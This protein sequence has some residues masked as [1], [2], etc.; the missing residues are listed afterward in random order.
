MLNFKTNDFLI[1]KISFKLIIINWIT[2]DFKFNFKILDFQYD[3]YLKEQL[4]WGEYNMVDAF[5]EGKS[6]LI[7]GCTGFVGK[8][9]L[10]KILFSLPQVKKVYVLVRPKKATLAEER[11]RKEIID[12][13]IFDRLRAR[14]ANFDSFIQTK[15][16]PIEG[17]MIQEGLALNPQDRQLLTENVNI[18]MNSAASIDF[19]QRLDQALQINTLGTLRII[20]LGSQCRNLAAFVQVSTA[21]VN[22]I[23]K[24][25]IEEKIYP[26]KRNPR[27]LLQELLALSVE[28]IELKTPEI[29]ELYP[30]T[31]SFTKNL[32]EH[33]IQE[34]I[35]TMPICILRPTI[36]GSS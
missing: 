18:I 7:T 28:E 30:N 31:Y 10:E 5:Y 24:G 33:I 2:L 17:D 32:T 11:M 22:C 25:W 21:Y 34:E 16:H 8:V 20:E 9:L 4:I 13:P 29:L 26:M 19:N 1:Q 15:L 27:L 3:R 36:I 14:E 6:I 23:Q 12:S 35:R